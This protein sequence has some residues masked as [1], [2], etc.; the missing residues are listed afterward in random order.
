MAER[1]GYA[2]A[3]GVEY[4]PENDEALSAIVNRYFA[5]QPFEDKASIERAPWPQVNSILCCLKGRSIP[6]KQPSIARLLVG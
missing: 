1:V 3:L 2:T 5:M 4:R 6:S